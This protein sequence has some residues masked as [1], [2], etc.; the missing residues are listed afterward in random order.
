MNTLCILHVASELAP[1]TGNGLLAREVSHLSS[2]MAEL[3]LDVTVAVPGHR[4]PEPTSVGLARRLRPL[5]V[6][7]TAPG[8]GDRAV[9]AFESTVHEGKLAGGRVK[10][11]ALDVPAGLREDAQRGAWAFCQAAVTAMQA[12]LRPGAAPDVVI[13]GPG[14]ELA[15]S[16]ARAV[17]R[18]DHAPLTL[19]ALRDQSDLS[20]VTEIMP[21]VDLVVASSPSRAEQVRALPATD[22]LG[23]ALEGA[24]QRQAIHGILG[25]IDTLAWNPQHDGLDSRNDMDHLAASKAERKRQLKRRLG[26]RGGAQA[27]L[28]ALVGP[29]D[30]DVLTETAAEELA[31]CDT[32]LVVLAH[33]ERDRVASQRFEHLARRGRGVLLSFA[34]LDEL[35]TLERELLCAADFALFAG[36]H[37]NTALCELQAMHYGVA[38]IAVRGP[39]YSDLLT[40]FEMRT[41]TGSGF[42][43]DADRQGSLAAAVDRALRVYRQPRA[44]KV[45]IER[46][47][48]FD[49]SWRTAAIRHTELIIEARRGRHRPATAS[50]VQSDVQGDAAAAAP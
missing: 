20:T 50:H 30:D 25:G 49:L 38:P 28:L 8:T 34:T 36:R 15:A 37:P 14:T 12:G 13:V 11:L 21:H 16:L 26:L 1:L 4:I 41:G 5:V 22:P 27:S 29:F 9:D 23:R 19:L 43:F 45:L 32:L 40:E 35:R 7:A 48:R 10:V 47:V 44:F 46:A 17:W 18:G 33:A 39:V 2:A 31:L 3:G 42:L 6:P 24:V